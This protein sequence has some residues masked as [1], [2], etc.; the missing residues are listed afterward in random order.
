MAKFP[1]GDQAIKKELRDYYRRDAKSYQKRRF[2]Q[3][4]KLV[5]KAEMDLLFELLKPCSKDLL[6]DVAAGTGRF[7]RM[8]EKFKCS[9]V[10]CDLATEMLRIA[11]KNKNPSFVQVD[12][13][14]LPFKSCT[15]DKSVALRFLFH[16]NDIEKM[17]I[18][19]EMLR[20]T[21]KKGPV[22]FDLQNSR[23]LFALLVPIRN[24]NLN[25]PTD[26]RELEALLNKIP[27]ISY[28]FFFS[29][30]IPRG[31]HRHLPMKISQILLFFEQ[32]LPYNVKKNF[33]STVFCRVCL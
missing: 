3:G 14:R 20:V 12:G 1:V 16:F 13:F 4:G 11:A 24:R 29:F 7:E 19:E 21:K 32:R 22:V 33:C 17:Q 30:L 10:S 6:L 25:L 15:F 8:V 27:G 5:H 9:V 18:L 31:I 2:R 23:G 26:P 28:N